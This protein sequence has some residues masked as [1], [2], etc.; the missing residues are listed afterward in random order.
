MVLFANVVSKG[1]WYYQNNKDTIYRDCVPILSDPK[2]SY[3]DA[4]EI[5]NYIC[6]GNTGKKS[7]FWNCSSGTFKILN[8]I[9]KKFALQK[10]ELQKIFKVIDKYYD[11]HKNSQYTVM[12][13]IWIKNLEKMG[14]VFTA[15]QKAIFK[16][17]GYVDFNE[18]IKNMENITKEYFNSF[19]SNKNYVSKILTSKDFF[20]KII[21]KKKFIISRDNLE[22]YLK[23]Y[24]ISDS[25]DEFMYTKI[26][27]F[28]ESL[29]YKFTILDATIVVKSLRGVSFELNNVDD[30]IFEKML[31]NIVNFFQERNI[32]FTYEMCCNL[33]SDNSIYSSHYYKIK[34]IYDMGYLKNDNF[35]D[36]VM[37]KI[38]I[39]NIDDS[40]KEYIIDN[41]DEI[42]YT[43]AT[44]LL[45][46]IKNRHG[47]I[48]KIIKTNKISLIESDIGFKYACLNCNQTL[49]K[50]YLNNKFSPR[51]EHIICIS[52]SLAGTF[53]KTKIIELLI[54]YGLNITEEIYAI[55][56][57]CCSQNAV[58]YHSINVNLPLI[59]LEYQNLVLNKLN[60]PCNH[61]TYAEANI[62]SDDIMLKTYTILPNIH[63]LLRCLFASNTAPSWELCEYIMM[64]SHKDPTSAE[65]LY[66]F[67]GYVPSIATIAKINKCSARYLYLLKYHN[68]KLLS[69]G[70]EF[71]L[72]KNN[73]FSCAKTPITPTTPTTE[74]KL[75]DDTNQNANNNANNNSIN[76]ADHNVEH[77]RQIEYIAKNDDSEDDEKLVKKTQ[78]TTKNKK[79]VAVKVSNV[80]RGK[81]QTKN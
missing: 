61:L 20:L 14:V 45:I 18:E 50:Y 17:I 58:N 32:F 42:N 28:F 34:K 11:L 65:I 59:S 62:F 79:K 80:P 72:T 40:A 44:I 47:M 56:E 25:S 57:C 54:S 21:E 7:F 3:N 73:L 4:I 26:L 33:R 1:H 78:K 43:P 66:D 38:I 49:I 41:Q 12:S 22:N 76:S 23:F 10:K 69:D 6:K 8:E 37:K 31:A 67:F 71:I 68:I 9:T 52:L 48:E 29:G 5:I 77:V 53:V 35:N 24:A 13:F 27:L 36:E 15:D 19:F 16:K 63:T 74:N 2:L 64:N 30:T 60:R 75:D 55:L 81:K 70:S 39:S 46:V 51:I